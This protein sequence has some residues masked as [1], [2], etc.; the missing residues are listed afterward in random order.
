MLYY[1]F[2]FFF[3]QLVSKPGILPSLPEQEAAPSGY[4]VFCGGGHPRPQPGEGP[5]G[6]EKTRRLRQELLF[7]QAR[8]QPRQVNGVLGGSVLLSPALPPNK[9]VKEI[10]WS[11][12]S[13]TGT[14]IQVAEFGPDGFERPDPK[15]RFKDRLEMVN[16]TALRIGVLERGDSGVYGARLKLHPALVEDQSFHLSVYESVPSPRTRS[17]LLASTVEWCNLTLQCQG[18][19][20][21]AVNVTWK[22]DNVIRDLT[23]DRHQLSPDGTTLRVALPPTAANV[24]YACTV[25]NPADQKVVLFD[26]QAICQ[27]GGGQ[28]SFSKSGYI[29]LTLILLAVSL[30][31]AFWCWRMNSEKA[32]DPAA[33]PTVPAEESPSDPQY[34]EIVRR[35]PPEGND[36]GLSHPENNPEQSPPQKA[37]VTTVYEQIRQA[38]EDTAEEAPAEPEH[39]DFPEGL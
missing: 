38:P 8:A 2:F 4:G 28:T 16:E 18:A 24:T 20:K 17:Q 15:D 22:R 19:G 9:T 7:G 12:S 31:G 23:S 13:G 26:L 35:S 30:G 34:A 29:V 11:F 21:G 39:R 10:E 27:S 6:G 1:F 33:T 37:P 25:S 36:Q 14:T 5:A 3:W 32:A